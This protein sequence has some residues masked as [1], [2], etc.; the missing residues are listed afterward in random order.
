MRIVIVKCLRLLSD[1][2]VSPLSDSTL[3][4]LH[5]LVDVLLHMVQLMFNYRFLTLHFS[6][7]LPLHLFESVA[8]SFF[9]LSVLENLGSCSESSYNHDKLNL[10]IISKSLAQAL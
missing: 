7:F 9:D 6:L 5:G 4:C 3:R 8:N 10:I 1:R 2:I